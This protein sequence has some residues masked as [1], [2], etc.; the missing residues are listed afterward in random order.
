M[1]Y[2][3]DRLERVAARAAASLNMA[4]LH[5]HAQVA[6]EQ[7]LAREQVLVPKHHTLELEF[8]N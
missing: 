6:R 5:T 1:V 3:L 8:E 2:Q 4:W 7:D